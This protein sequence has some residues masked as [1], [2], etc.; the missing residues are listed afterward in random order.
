MHRPRQLTRSAALAVALAALSTP[1]AFAQQAAPAAASSASSASA[2]ASSGIEVRHGQLTTR[3]VAL[4]DDILRVTVAPGGAYPEDASWAVPA[5]VRA[6][7]A[8]VTPMPNGFATR[9]LRVELQDGRL[10]VHDLAGKLVSADAAPAAFD[11]HAFTLKKQLPQAEH[12]FGMGDKTGGLDRR[13]KSFVD[14]NTDAY[15]FGPGDDPIY[16]SIPF[17]IGVGGDG[18]R[19]ARRTARSTTT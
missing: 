1:A 12:Y 13:G 7:R 2:A 6:G 16:K 11:G 17:F 4:T 10:V 18:W 8:H 9:T 14:W 19:S 15:G 3:V 5:A